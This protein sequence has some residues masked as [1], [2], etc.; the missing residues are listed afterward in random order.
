MSFVKRENGKWR[1]EKGKFVCKPK[2]SPD[3]ATGADL[4]PQ[5]DPDTIQLDPETNQPVPNAMQSASNAI[6]S[7]SNGIQSTSK[8]TQPKTQRKRKRHCMGAVKAKKTRKRTYPPGYVPRVGKKTSVVWYY[9]ESIG[10]ENGV[11]R[12]QCRMC[13]VIFKNPGGS[14]TGMR[15]HLDR[16]HT[17]CVELVLNEPESESKTQIAESYILEHCIAGPDGVLKR[18]VKQDIKDE[19]GEP[20]SPPPPPLSVEGGAI[21]E[22]GETEIFEGDFESDNNEEDFKNML[23][24]SIASGSSTK[25]HVLP[26]PP[27]GICS[28]VET[29]N[30]TKLLVNL[31]ASSMRPLQSAN[32]SG[33]MNMLQGLNSEYL[34]DVSGQN[35]N[36]MGAMVDALND[37]FRDLRDVGRREL[38]DQFISISLELWTKTNSE[39]YLLAHAHYVSE[40]WTFDSKFLGMQKLPGTNLLTPTTELYETIAT[41]MDS[42]VEDMQIKRD[43]ITMITFNASPFKQEETVAISSIRTIPCF[44]E[45][46]RQAFVI[47]N[48][49]ATQLTG[50]DIIEDCKKQAKQILPSYKEIKRHPA[51]FIETFRKFLVSGRGNDLPLNTTLD[52]IDALGRMQQ[53]INEMLESLLDEP[54]IPASLILPL[55]FGIQSLFNY[56]VDCDNSNWP[57]E[58]RKAIA[59]A[60][61]NFIQT[62]YNFD[63]TSNELGDTTLAI[64]SFLDPRYKGMNFIN[65]ELRQALHETITELLHKLEKE[66][67]TES[68]TGHIISVHSEHPDFAHLN[69]SSSDPLN[70]DPQPSTSRQSSKLATIMTRVMGRK[71]MPTTPSSRVQE[72]LA[73][74]SREPDS[75]LGV[76]PYQWWGNNSDRYPTLSQLAKKYFCIRGISIHGKFAFTPAGKKF[77]NNLSNLEPEFVEKML[78]IRKYLADEDEDQSDTRSNSCIIIEDRLDIK[79]E[80]ITLNNTSLME[81]ET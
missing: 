74:Y 72:E 33:F 22:V 11:S 9:F 59:A 5:I 73:N 47:L 65:G 8:T 68:D 20:T 35:N 19:K 60:V 41:A 54:V 38:E 48:N 30:N 44:N 21:G 13:F 61:N 67:P 71:S 53:P 69:A 2:I 51:K 1:N 43:K 24:V 34:G 39:I 58:E 55:I 4:P 36:I 15:S 3:S 28:V 81:E 79:T 16:R 49:G 45:V 77:H 63:I 57:Q 42:L 75:L 14:T 66:M 10:H 17:G 46:F 29:E 27:P 12:G 64:C 80:M 7:T 76:D 32:S 18:E 62:S 70:M 50:I 56:Q 52:D 6:Q 37:Q 31:L 40:Y 78:F 25:R 26:G 23:E